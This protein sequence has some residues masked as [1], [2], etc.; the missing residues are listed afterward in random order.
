MLRDYFARERE[1]QVLINQVM[2][3]WAGTKIPG[4]LTPQQQKTILDAALSK[5]QA[6]GGFSL[7]SF[8]GDWKRHD[9]T[10]LETRSDGYAT[11]VGWD[12]VTGVGSPIVNAL[13]PDLARGGAFPGGNLLVSVTATPS[14]GAAPLA[15]S[16]YLTVQGGSGTYPLVGVSYGDGNA[17]LTQTG[18]VTHTFPAAGVYS[19]QAF[20]FDSGGNESVSVPV[21]VVVGGGSLLSVTLSTSSSTP[22]VGQS[23]DLTTTIVGGTAPYAYNYSFG[24]G[25][26]TENSPSAVIAHQYVVAGTF[27]AAVVVQDSANPPDGGVSATLPITVGG[28]TPTNCTVAPAPFT[29]TPIHGLPLRDAPAD[30]P[31]LFNVSGGTTGTGRPAPT[32]T[33]TSND[34]YVTACDCSIFRAPGSYWVNASGVDSV[35][36]RA[37]ANTT[38]LGE[39]CAACHKSG[40]EFSVDRVHQ[41]IF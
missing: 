6:D 32:L 22:S 4:L 1:S 33:L 37:Y 19:A 21:V 31:A 16:F 14:R 40:E 3:V 8:V 18:T 28:G 5:Q 39:S 17:S 7:S 10:P 9:G 38:V 2:L 20:V 30:Y 11:G 23:I 41:R 27:C 12:P 26:F 24:D 29:L 36:D 13:V 35:G 34:S 25:S 15:V